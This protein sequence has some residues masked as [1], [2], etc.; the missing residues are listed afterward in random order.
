MNK[1]VLKSAALLTATLILAPAIAQTANAD[2]AASY[3]SDGQVTFTPN[4]NPTNPVDPANPEVPVT[5]VNPPGMPAPQPPTAGPLSIVFASSF[6]FGTHD[7]QASDQ[8]YTA[9]A[10]KLDDGTSR[11]NYVQVNDS[12][13]NYTGW[14]LSVTQNADFKSAD[15]KVLT[16]AQVT[17]GNGAIQGKGTDNPAD[18]SA[19]TTTLT[20]GTASGTILGATNGKGSGNNLLNFGSADGKTNAD[21]SVT[22]AVPGTTTKYATAYTTSLTWTL[23]DTPAN[24]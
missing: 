11:D 12:R 6:D 24:P 13:G 3:G 19:A 20:P 2:T 16:G 15:G 8:T 5:P 18:V 23:A 14:S 22:L 10:Q 4:T 9:A 21:T 17:L 1:L 7:I